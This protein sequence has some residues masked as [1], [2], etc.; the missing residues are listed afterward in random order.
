MNFYWEL[1]DPSSD[2]ELVLGMNTEVTAYMDKMFHYYE[3]TRLKNKE[4]KET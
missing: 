4:R 3:K 2:N 1:L